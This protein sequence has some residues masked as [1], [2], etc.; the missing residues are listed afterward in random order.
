MDALGSDYSDTA[1]KFKNV[2]FTIK[3]SAILI[4]D[5]SNCMVVEVLYVL[6]MQGIE[7]DNLIYGLAKSYESNDTF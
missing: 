4:D 2:M 6:H 7:E 3:N 1:D 5:A